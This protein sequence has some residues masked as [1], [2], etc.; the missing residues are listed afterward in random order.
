[1]R[2]AI[3]KLPPGDR[4]PD[5]AWK[6]GES[7]PGKLLMI[8]ALAEDDLFNAAR[9]HTPEER[10]AF[11][12]SACGSDE[13]LRA[14]VE[15]LLSAHD[16]ANNPLDQS[17]PGL[18]VTA[19]ELAA[20]N[21][22]PDVVKSPPPQRV[23]MALIGGHE[24]SG[25]GD[26]Y[27]LLLRRLRIFS[28]IL[29][30]ALSILLCLSLWA[31][32]RQIGRA[33]V[34]GQANGLDW[35]AELSILGLPLISSAVSA[36]FLFRRPPSSLGGLR[37][38]ELLV[39]G[40]LAATILASCF[41]P[42]AY[43]LVE[44]A[45]HEPYRVRATFLSAYRNSLALNWFSLMVVYG[46]VIPNTWRRAA[47]TV[48][49]LALSPLAVFAVVALWL[50]PLEHGIVINVLCGWAFWNG[51]AAVLVVFASSRIE[52]L[53][54]E[55][56]KARKLGQYVLKERLGSG[57]MGE[58][59]RAE[60][61]LLRRPCAIK[62]IRPERAGEPENLR[63]F[64]REVQAT[65]TLTHPNTVHVYDYGHA[66]DGTFYYAMEYLPGLTLE[67]L[68]KRDGPLPPA[69]AVRLLRQV[70]GA[71]AEAH[72][73][74]LTH[75]DVKPGN[76]MVCERGGEPDVAKL[77]DFGLVLAPAG[78]PVS[79]VQLTR[80]GTVTGT[81]GYL[82][83]EQAAGRTEVDARSDVYSVGGLAYFLL[84]G[85]PPFA[86]RS[87]VETLAAH[88]YETPRPIREHA[89]D[90]P[91]DLE[92]VVLRCLAKDPAGRYSDAAALDVAL[93]RVT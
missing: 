49:V 79:D 19:V 11:L 71:L 42:F 45:A 73:R 16:A 56:A 46:T 4:R 18:D 33:A 93:A 48:G 32:W 47:V 59:Y 89:P 51:L 12:R 63:R 68:V 52:V 80:A 61:A 54:Q 21:A 17:P 24:R 60:H 29:A 43:S 78:D 34:E 38:I 91:A 23:R 14:R 64:E 92:A 1:M 37:R 26:L 27:G 82:S 36:A 57:G 90:V 28:S 7:L 53:R 67:E 85:R 22:A 70:C 74:G 9:R 76:V 31:Y 30:A 41:H 20:G 35:L 6:S 55:A 62:V 83:P 8:V 25:Y 40:P 72:G 77:L 88:L 65:A 66:E 69:R 13:P 15:R 58:V 87:P 86:G 3:L 84:T 44:Q 5:F 81:P 10:A 2:A 75:R 50:K 39:V